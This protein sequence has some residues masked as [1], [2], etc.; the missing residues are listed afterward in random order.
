GLSRPDD[1]RTLAAPETAALARREIQLAKDAG[2]NMM[3][4]HVKPAPKATLEAADEL[5]MLLYEEPPIGRIRKSRFMKERC[6]RAVRE[7]IL[8][9]R[10]H[11]SVVIWGMLHAT[12]GGAHAIKDGLCTLARSLDPSRIVIDDS[13]GVT[14][15]REGSR[16]MRPYHDTL[17]AYDDL[18][19]YLRA[20][21]DGDTAA[22]FTHNGHP[23]QMYFLSEFGFGGMEDL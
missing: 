5:G 16:L 20:P 11:P 17:E 13:G 15:T 9:D 3:R 1:P 19:I 14:V 4:L 21:V 6:E 12:G 18:H 2:F 8:R 22:Y 23:D 10:N 7:M